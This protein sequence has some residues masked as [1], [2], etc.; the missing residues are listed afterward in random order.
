MLVRPGDIV[1]CAFASVASGS[2]K[3]VPRRSA[4]GPAPVGRCWCIA[5]QTTIQGFTS[6]SQGRSRRLL[7]NAC[8]KKRRR[9]AHCKFKQQVVRQ[10][11]RRREGQRTSAK[12]HEHVCS[13]LPEALYLFPKTIRMYLASCHWTSTTTVVC[14]THSLDPS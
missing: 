4:R 7:Q 2:T 13:C 8:L 11:A 3:A 6:R 14:C 9:G 12:R 1:Q 5:R 10:V